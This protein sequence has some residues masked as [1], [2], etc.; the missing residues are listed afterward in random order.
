MKQTIEHRGVV[1]RIDDGRVMVRIV[2]TSAC[3]SCKVAS[4][5][6]ASE[7]KVKTV[8]VYQTSGRNFQ[9]GDEVTVVASVRTG[10]N[11]VVLAF[12]VPFF[13]MVGAVFLCSRFFAD[14]PTSALIGIGSLVPYYFGLYLSRDRIRKSF[15]F[16]IQE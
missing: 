1:E 9:V 8:E 5:C 3:A 11:A 15:A 13:I 6:H 2:Q 16:K 10:F 7:S 4:Q 14:E 12:V